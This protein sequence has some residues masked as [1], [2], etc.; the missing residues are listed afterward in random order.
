MDE[1]HTEIFT[2][3]LIRDILW[4]TYQSTGGFGFIFKIIKH[5]GNTTVYACIPRRNGNLTNEKTK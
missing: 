3:G 5:K 2:D 4:S 1:T